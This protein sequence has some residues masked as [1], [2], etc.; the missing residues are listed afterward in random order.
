M[1]EISLAG[2]F[3]VAAIA[4]GAP[5]ILGLFPSVRL[6][7]IVVE[8]LV[9]VV[10]GPALLGLVEVDVALEVLS[11]LGLAFLLFLAGLEIDLDRLRAASPGIVASGF[12][13]SLSLG[14]GVGGALW[15]FDVVESPLFVAIVLSSTALGLVVPVLA[16]A[17]QLDTAAGKT[18]IAAASVADFGAVILLSVLF[19]E[20]SGGVGATLLLL[21]AFIALVAL[22]SV[23]VAEVERF[24]RLGTVLNRLQD[25]SAQI[26]VR[27]ALVLLVGLAWL[28]QTFGLEAI[29]GAF[30]AGAMLRLLDRDRAMTHPRFREKLE[31]VGFGA[32]V[33]F[34]FVVSGL[35]LDL[36]VLFSGEAVTL[37]LI[38]AFLL[39]ILLVRGLPAILLYRRFMRP[40]NAAATGLLQATTLPFI[41]AAT[42]IGVEL[43]ELDTAVAAALV[44][45][46][47]LSVILFPSGA[48]RL[49][50]RG[51]A[52]SPR[53]GNSWGEEV[54]RKSSTS[55][56]TLHMDNTDD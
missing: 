8:I 7:S 18:V 37:L 41:V 43:G 5:F 45:A 56:S 40:R 27:G 30:V 10:L 4:F 48:L 11:L 14:L 28:A 3:A 16:D 23:A 32:F 19:S 35:R 29:L 22:I 17:G 25:T 34:F 42:E 46:G 31:A 20:E 36:Q 24:G 55:Q 21:S 12:A 26:R 49:L 13:L 52:D 54:P 9:G 44:L 53:A 2:I 15:I 38:P 33:P 6:P 39:A 51:S 47:L 50:A 1:P